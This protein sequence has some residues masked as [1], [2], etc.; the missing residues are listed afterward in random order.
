MIL[1]ILGGILLLFKSPT[2]EILP[3]SPK[4]TILGAIAFLISQVV[5]N[6]LIENQWSWNY[7]YSFLCL[8]KVSTSHLAGYLRFGVSLSYIL[9]VLA[10]LQL[11]FKKHEQK[12]KLND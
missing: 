2:K 7:I 5:F 6:S 10:S 12:R 4:I 1:F 8:K 9:V 3:K 11:I